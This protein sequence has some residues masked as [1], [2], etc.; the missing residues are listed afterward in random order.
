MLSALDMPTGLV[1]SPHQGGTPW[2][3][4]VKG[5]FSGAA[6]LFP[7]KHL[8]GLHVAQ[9]PIQEYFSFGAN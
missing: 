2:P 6:D 8:G 9:H 5:G 3:L 7:I 4:E 1:P